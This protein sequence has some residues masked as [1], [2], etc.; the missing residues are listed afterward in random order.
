M[1]VS[2]CVCML[3]VFYVKNVCVCVCVC[4]QDGVE[5]F[6]LRSAFASENL[7][8]DDILWRHKEAFSD[9]ITSV[10]KSWYTSLQEHIESEVHTHTHTHTLVCTH[11]HTHTREHTH[12]HTHTHTNSLVRTH[13]LMCE[14]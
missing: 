5:K 6:L 1:R 10:K 3:S 4:V 11:T 9:G 14:S 7:I 2:V 13:G 12:T 8:P